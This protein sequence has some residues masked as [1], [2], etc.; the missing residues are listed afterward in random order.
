M[1]IISECDCSEIKCILD[2]MIRREWDPDEDSADLRDILSM[3]QE[4]EQ[5]STEDYLKLNQLRKTEDD[6]K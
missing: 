3:I 6:N 4:L 1:Y 5:L 2:E